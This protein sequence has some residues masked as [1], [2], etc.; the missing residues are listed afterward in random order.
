[1]WSYHTQ[2]TINFFELV[3][4]AVTS[5]DELMKF[6]SLASYTCSIGKIIEKLANSSLLRSITKLASYILTIIG[7]ERM[8]QTG[9]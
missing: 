7:H 4:C 8:C 2:K 6:A 5:Y 1:M 3:V 9:G